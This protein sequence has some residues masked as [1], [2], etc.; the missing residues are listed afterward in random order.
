MT[1]SDCYRWDAQQPH[2]WAADSVIIGWLFTFICVHCVWTRHTAQR[3]YSCSEVTS[4]FRTSSLPVFSFIS[5]WLVLID[6]RVR[7]TSPGRSILCRIQ[8]GFYRKLFVVCTRGPTEPRRPGTLLLTGSACGWFWVRT[9]QVSDWSGDGSDLSGFV[10][11]TSLRFCQVLRF[12]SSGT[13]FSRHQL[14]T[15]S[16][17][18][19]RFSGAA[20]SDRWAPPSL[21][22]AHQAG[23]FRVFKAFWDEVKCFILLFRLKHGRQHVWASLLLD[24]HPS[25]SSAV[26]TNRHVE[27]DFQPPSAAE[28]RNWFRRLNWSVLRCDIRLFG[29][30]CLCEVNRKCLQE[31][32]R[33]ESH[34]VSCASS[35]SVFLSAGRFMSAVRLLDRKWSLGLSSSD[36]LRK[37]LAGTF[38]NLSSRFH[39][40]DC[41]SR[42][43]D[44]GDATAGNMW[45]WELNSSVSRVQQADA[46]TRK[47]S[48]VPQVRAEIMLSPRRSRVRR[49]F[50][51]FRVKIYL[52]GLWQTQNTSEELKFMSEQRLF[53]FIQFHRC[54][55]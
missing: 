50:H 9:Q 43:S 54:R 40:A 11:L 35:S 41:F 36:A 8:T 48:C 23:V 29:G 25:S 33:A 30:V 20:G 16:D 17:L 15:L 47:K 18:P 55:K 44:S 21:P 28:G 32:W 31:G 14:W 37:H 4:C 12:L 7:T 6:H 26:W 2:R 10:L 42:T 1:S 22:S 52:K 51:H 39:G 27:S 49:S 45:S 19:A 53:I 3:G 46:A 34:A 38:F 5:S 24:L 13:V